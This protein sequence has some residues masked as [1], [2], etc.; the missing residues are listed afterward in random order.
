MLVNGKTLVIIALAVIIAFMSWSYPNIIRP[1]GVWTNDNDYDFFLQVMLP[2]FGLVISGFIGACG[3]FAMASE[4]TKNETYKEFIDQSHILLIIGCGA[5]IYGMWSWDRT[6]QMFYCIL[7]GPFIGMGLFNLLKKIK[8]IK[9]R[10]IAITISGLLL[11]ATYPFISGGE[12]SPFDRYQG[13]PIINGGTG[14]MI[15][16]SALSGSIAMCHM[17]LKPRCLA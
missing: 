2:R 5:L 11:I 7:G 17:L 10:S 3:A 12:P 8:I 15:L 14:L 4:L 1:E 6:Y 16:L 9:E 13:I